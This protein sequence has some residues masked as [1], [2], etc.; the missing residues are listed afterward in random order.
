MK[1]RPVMNFRLWHWHANLAVDSTLEY[2][3]I[4]AT[5]QPD[6]EAEGKVFLLCGYKGEPCAD[7][8]EYML[9]SRGEY[10]TV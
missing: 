6:W 8:V 7:G 1:I 2:D 10:E 5:N 9:L 3:A 4:D